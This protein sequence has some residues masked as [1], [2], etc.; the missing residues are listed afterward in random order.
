MDF[1]ARH[2]FL[3]LTKEQ[4]ELVERVSK[5]IYRPC[6]GNAVY[7]PDCNHGMAMLGLL[8]LMAAQGV[9]EEEMYRTALKVNSFWFPDTYLTIAEYFR[10]QG[11]VWKDVDPKEV[12]GAAY[13]SAAGYRRIASQVESSSVQGGS[14]GCGVDAGVPQPRRSSGCGVE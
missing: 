1:C 11:I 8:E 12:L 9:N 7:F 5:N 4:Q 2:S 14:G 13:S 10:H 6:C 3:V